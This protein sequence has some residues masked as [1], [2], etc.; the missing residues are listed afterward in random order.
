MHRKANIVIL[1]IPS[2]V[3]MILIIWL[4][5]PTSI[6]AQSIEKLE[7]TLSSLSA[8]QQIS[9]LNDQKQLAQNAPFEEQARYWYLLATAYDQNNQIQQ[10]IDAY[11]AAIDIT[12]KLVLPLSTLYPEAALNART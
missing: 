2:R 12:E 10:A 8:E 5:I 3:L 7:T 11:S 4:S 9:L 1:H 6:N